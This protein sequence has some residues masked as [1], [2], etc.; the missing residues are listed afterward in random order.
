MKY[1]VDT[2]IFNWLVDRKIADT[3]LPNDGEFFV[4]HIQIDEIN[5]TSNEE[6]RAR[7]FLTMASSLSGVIPTETT[8]IGRSRIGRSKLGSGKVYTSIKNKLDEING[9]KRSNI[10]DALIAE[11]SIVNSHTLLTADVDL[12]SVTEEQG[13][14]VQLFTCN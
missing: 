13:G 4:T 11:A 3:L 9:G 6:R 5:K 2:N 12:A 1:L 8:I 7:L 14:V 10:N